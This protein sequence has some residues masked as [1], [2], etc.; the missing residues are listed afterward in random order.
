VREHEPLEPRTDERRLTVTLMNIRTTL[1]NRTGLTD[2][3]VNEFLPKLR[4]EGYV[5]R[6]DEVA[7]F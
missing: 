7:C 4:D 5:L 1:K 6:G 2:D 3:Q